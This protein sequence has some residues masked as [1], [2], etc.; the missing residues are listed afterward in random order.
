MMSEHARNMGSAFLH[1]W[2]FS[3]TATTSTKAP[4]NMGA[5]LRTEGV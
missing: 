2:N 4:T 5:F 3:D 1:L